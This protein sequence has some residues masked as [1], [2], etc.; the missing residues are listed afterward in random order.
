MSRPESGRRATVNTSERRRVAAI[1][2]TAAVSAWLSF[3]IVAVTADDTRLRVAALPPFWWLAGLV[4]VA[5]ALAWRFRPGLPRVSPLALTLLLWL[6]YVP[7]R[8]P[9]AFL[10]WQGPIEIVVWLLAIVGISIASPPSLPL[11]RRAL[12]PVTAPWMAGVAAAVLF[13]A[14]AA[15]LRGQ[16]PIGDEPHYLMMTQSLLKDGDLRIENNHRNKDYASFAT[17]DLPIHYLARGTDGQIY[18]VHAPGVSMLVLPGFALFGYA[19]G[20]ATMI[21]LVAAASALAWRTAWLLTEQAEAAWITWASLFL[22]APIYL[23]AITVFPD[24][25]GAAATVV[26]VWTL[27]CL[28]MRRPVG[29]AQLVACSAALASLPWLHTRFAILAGA[30]GAIIGLRLISQGARRILLFV[31]VPAIALAAWLGFF[32]LIW[33][34]PDPRAQW[35]FSVA[36]KLEWIPRGALGILF[37]EQAGLFM[38]APAYVAAVVGSLVLLRSRPR[39]AMELGAAALLALA[40]VAG[41]ETWWGGQGAPAR[42]LVSM[43]PV[44]IPAIALAAAVPQSFGRAL[45]TFA[46]A[47]SVLLL[48]MKLVVDGGASTF[49]PE[50]GLNPLMA[51]LARSVDLRSGLPRMI[52]PLANGGHG[53]P[54]P[55]H[56]VARITMVWAGMATL[57]GALIAWFN[58][59]RPLSSSTTFTLVAGAAALTVMVGATAAWDADHRSGPTPTES[60]MAFIRTW[61]AD[62]LPVG[63]QW[64]RPYVTTPERLAS[65]IELRVPNETP[66][67][68]V[69]RALPPA[70]YDVY[71]TQADPVSAGTLAPRITADRPLET[72]TIEARREN[73]PYRFHL[74]LTPEWLQFQSDVPALD[75]LRIRLAAPPASHPA[76]TAVAGARYGDVRVFFADARAY[77]EPTGFWVQASGSASL[78][79]DRPSERTRPLGLRV[80]SREIANEVE[81]V[82]AGAPQR[83]ALARNQRHEMTIPPAADGVWKIAIRPAA[84][85]RPFDINPA[86]KD[87]RNLGVWVEVF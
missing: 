24:A 75:G 84:G 52:D 81:V 58:R 69:F 74:P 19:G 7:G 55:V 47:A 31:V 61:R 27:V 59:R 9:A 12:D 18:S 6:P 26:A 79:I 28:E 82:I 14:G 37:D 72:W 11:R 22:S 3:G 86:V 5:L 20:V 34:S 60:Q 78:I 39:L 15:Q 41:Y 10:I 71:A 83:L 45:A 70:D 30:L 80:E 66:D 4:A 77:P 54:I 36:S 67:R 38:A 49:N 44:A 50:V 33:G 40:G 62:R 87:Y 8:I 73:G 51:T 23:Q 2:V 42:Y 68:A 21:L 1:A 46:V 65:H 63:V 16:L 64:R 85:F 48:T 13:T 29:D 35:G 25:A 32:W 17:F 76:D 57:L 43:L 53:R 56:L